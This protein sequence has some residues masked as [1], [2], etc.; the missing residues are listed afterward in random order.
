MVH[1]LGLWKELWDRTG[2][3]FSVCQL[4]TMEIW[5]HLRSSVTEV[6]WTYMMKIGPVEARFTWHQIQWN[7]LSMWTHCGKNKIQI[8]SWFHQSRFYFFPGC[9]P[10][11]R[12]HRAGP[13][14]T[15]PRWGR[16]SEPAATCQKKTKVAVP[17][18][19]VN[20]VHKT[21]K[22]S[23]ASQKINKQTKIRSVF[24]KQ[25]RLFYVPRPEDFP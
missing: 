3:T 6:L 1:R 22:V 9:Q 15:W 12:P 5:P 23:L 14:H 2:T 16:H 10:Q 25:S 13:W 24:T 21:C 17:M 11:P 7:R 8:K 18:W 4:I 20:V 19:Q